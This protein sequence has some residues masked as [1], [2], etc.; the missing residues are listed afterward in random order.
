[1]KRQTRFWLLVVR[2]QVVLQSLN[3]LS[4]IVI[5]FLREGSH[6]DVLV[7]F[8]LFR[9]IL[10][11]HVASVSV[12]FFFLSL[13]LLFVGIVFAHFIHLRQ[14]QVLSFCLDV[15]D[16]NFIVESDARLLGST[17]RF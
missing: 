17:I 11:L 15:L 9:T 4:V 8:I 7:L 6:L 10:S 12:F 13:S 16:T 3:G 1:V 5:F 2:K 14:R